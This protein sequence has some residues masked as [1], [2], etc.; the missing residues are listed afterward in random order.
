MENPSPSVF[1]FTKKTMET[2][3]CISI[4]FSYLKVEE[5]LYLL[6]CVTIFIQINF[7]CN[8]PDFYSNYV[9]IL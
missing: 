7:N 4:V 2:R 8:K 9:Y 5:S 3:I 6:L 1:F